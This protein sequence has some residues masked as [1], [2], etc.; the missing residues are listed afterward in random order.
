MD[1]RVILRKHVYLSKIATY[2]VCNQKE[3]VLNIIHWI[4]R[5]APMR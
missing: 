4:A 3:I 1:V 5:F 2:S